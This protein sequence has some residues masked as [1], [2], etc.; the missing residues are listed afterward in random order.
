MKH[1]HYILLALIGLVLVLVGCQFGRGIWEGM[2]DKE[3]QQI[4]QVLLTQLN[5]VIDQAKKTGSI[6][7]VKSIEVMETMKDFV[8]QTQAGKMNLWEFIGYVIGIATGT[9]L[10]TRKIR[11]MLANG[12][13]KNNETKNS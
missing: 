1:L 5:E 10:A 4:A 13:G 8:R 6:D 12:I 7:G 9:Y 2:T 11:L 3:E